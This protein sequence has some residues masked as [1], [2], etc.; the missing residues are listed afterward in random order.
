VR[1]VLDTD[2]YGAERPVGGPF[3]FDARLTSQTVRVAES[4]PAQVEWQVDTIEELASAASSPTAG[5]KRTWAGKA[6]VPP[7]T[8]SPKK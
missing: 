1:V 8:W 3:G 7:R 2:I 5:P 4:G 6:W